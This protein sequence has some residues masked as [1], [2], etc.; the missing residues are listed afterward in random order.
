MEEKRIELRRKGLGLR[1]N[2]KE[3][4]NAKWCKK[5]T[6]LGWQCSGAS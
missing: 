1:E 6:V 3:N 4:P 5:E 2:L